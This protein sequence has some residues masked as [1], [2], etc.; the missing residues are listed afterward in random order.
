MSAVVNSFE[1]NSP[2]KKE[3]SKKKFPASRQVGRVAAAFRRAARGQRVAARR[4]YGGEYGSDLQR[5]H[6]E[7]MG[8][9]WGP[10]HRDRHVREALEPHFHPSTTTLE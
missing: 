4:M 8:N 1:C 5:N 9:E 7:R 3:D 6:L 10:H 2:F